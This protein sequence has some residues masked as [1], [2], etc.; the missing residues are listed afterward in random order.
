M[1]DLQSKY[2]TIETDHSH[3]NRKIDKLSKKLEEL[4]EDRDKL[5]NRISESHD[6]QDTAEKLDLKSLKKPNKRTSTVAFQEK[7]KIK[8]LTEIL[9][10]TNLQKI[11]SRNQAKGLISYL[12]SGNFTQFKNP[13]PLKN[14][15]KSITTIYK[16]KIKDQKKVVD[17]KKQDFDDYV[18]DYHMQVFSTVN[19]MGDT[20]F[21][22]FVLSLKYHANYFRVNLFSRF[23]GLI[24]G[25]K[26]N[27]VQ[28]DKYLEGLEFMDNS[29]KGF[30]VKNSDS[31]ARVFYPY[32]RAEDYIKSV[33]DKK[34][35]F[36]EMYELKRKVEELKEE[37]KS[38]MNYGLIDAD[39]F[40]EKV[41]VKYESVVNRTKQYVVDAFDSCDLDGS[42]TCTVNEWVLM[43]R[44]IEHETFDLNTCIQLFFANSNKIV[45]GESCM[46]FDRFAAVCTDNRMF[47][48]ESQFRFLGVS[49]ERTLDAIFK[50][51]KSN[52]VERTKEMHGKLS[53]LTSLTDEEVERWKENIEVL[54][55]HLLQ[56]NQLSKKSTAIA[57]HLTINE[58]NRIKLEEQEFEENEEAVSADSQD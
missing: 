56:G 5:L 30:P 49:E 36:E 25:I 11:A 44:Y 54:N 7:E 42:K 8:K 53:E 41:I 43:C 28:I 23:M 37:D 31:S 45:N 57:Y 13:L 47:S 3:C 21:G 27:Q 24:Q 51:L 16:E 52:W 22:F 39:R 50:E 18:Y 26:Y 10:K 9:S 17:S 12:T 2:D 14:L 20:K 48:E 38:G 46:T 55:N 32:A 35:P 58:L 29:T 19:G 6:P 40:L 15:L 33:F 1:K 34:I 4:T